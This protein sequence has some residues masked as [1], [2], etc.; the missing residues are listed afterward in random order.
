V[1]TTLF[2]INAALC[3]TIGASLASEPLP[4]EV[5][6]HHIIPKLNSLALSNYA[7]TNKT[8]YN[9][10]KAYKAENG[11]DDKLVL[12][13][14]PSST[15]MMNILSNRKDNYSTEFEDIRTGK[16]WLIRT[17]S[18]KSKEQLIDALSGCKLID[19][20]ITK[21]ELNCYYR[22]KGLESPIVGIVGAR[23]LKPSQSA[24]IAHS[25]APSNPNIRMTGRI[26]LYSSLVRCLMV[27]YDTYQRQEALKLLPDDANERVDCVFN[28]TRSPESL[29]PSNPDLVHKEA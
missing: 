26:R 27:P 2:L 7:S 1:K 8:N 25:W 17:P 29:K 20:C 5:N 23:L 21:D 24:L 9:A 4:D 19:I 11:I 22:K 3:F 13:H 16:E 12:I 10:V 15:E 18:I 28:Q 6:N 14:C